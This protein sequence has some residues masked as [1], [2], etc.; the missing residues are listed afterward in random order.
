MGYYEVFNSVIIATILGV[1]WRV[2]SRVEKKTN[3]IV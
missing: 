1:V 2:L 3:R